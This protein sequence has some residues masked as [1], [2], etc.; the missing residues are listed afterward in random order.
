LV[1][2]GSKQ[3]FAKSGKGMDIGRLI[4]PGRSH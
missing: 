4:R 1:A 2:S 3:A